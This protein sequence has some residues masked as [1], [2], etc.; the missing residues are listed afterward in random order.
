M[1]FVDANVFLRYLTSAQTNADLPRKAHAR[2]LFAQIETGDLLASASEVVIHE[3]CFILTSPKHY[4][5]T[6]ETVAPELATIIKWPGFVFPM[7]DKLIYLR[8]LEIWMH[9]PR[10]EFSDSVIAAR[11]ERAGHELA[12]F[13]RHFRDLPFL[14]LWQPET[15]PP[16]SL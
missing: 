13:D 11:C 6:A 8:A 9:H 3:V 1:I 12:T 4:R 15:L 10:L 16:N 2:S 7:A 14:Q 5:Y